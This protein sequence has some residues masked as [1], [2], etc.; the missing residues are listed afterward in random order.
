MLN[1]YRRFIPG[2]A[3]MQALI[4]DLL[5]AKKG[6]AAINWTE[7]AQ[8]AFENTKQSLTQTTLLAHPRANTELALFT[9]ASDHNIGAVLQQYQDGW[10][11]LAFFF[12]KLSQIQH[13]RPRVT[14]HLSINQTLS[15]YGRSS[16]IC[17]LHIFVIYTNLLSSLFIRSQRSAHHVSFDISIS[18]DSSPRTFDT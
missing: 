11:P 15:S 9:D 13:F 12:K 14:S 7:E 5:G 18:S 10:D 16:S 8:Q 3:K 4:H 1:F 6:A 17:N 2:A